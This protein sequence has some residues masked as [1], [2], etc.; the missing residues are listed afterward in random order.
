MPMA[1]A[2]LAQLSGPEFDREF[3]RTVG[4]ADHQ[5]TIVKFDAAGHQT[6]DPQLRAWIQKMLPALQHH[7]QEAQLLSQPH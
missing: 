4:I 6:S 3:V 7:L 1:V 2:L 5:A